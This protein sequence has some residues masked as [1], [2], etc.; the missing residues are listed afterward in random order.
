MLASSDV[1]VISGEEVALQHK[2]VSDMLIDRL[3]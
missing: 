1:I 2:L 3:P